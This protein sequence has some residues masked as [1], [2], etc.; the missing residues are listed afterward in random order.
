MVAAFLRDEPRASLLP[1]G[2]LLGGPSRPGSLTHTLRFEPRASQTS[3]LFVA[4]IGKAEAT[5]AVKAA[6]VAAMV[7]AAHAEAE[8]ESASGAAGWGE[9]EGAA[10]V[11]TSADWACGP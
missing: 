11:S 5:T 9:G 7:A 10:A 8:A 2:A 6:H 3:A 1:V 4:R